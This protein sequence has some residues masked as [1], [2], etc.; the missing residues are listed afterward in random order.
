MF[1]DLWNLIESIIKNINRV[2]DWLNYEISFTI[3]FKIPIIFPDGFNI[4]F[5]FTPLEL[6]G[7]GV[8]T[9]IILWVIKSLIPLG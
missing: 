2:W 7:V 5:D 3:P 4:T 6:L 8:T 1:A 9:L